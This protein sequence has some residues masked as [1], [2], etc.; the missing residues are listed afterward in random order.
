MD[1]GDRE[2]YEKAIH[3]FKNSQTSYDN[4]SKW[5]MR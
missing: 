1:I 4:I 3:E 5:R 2:D